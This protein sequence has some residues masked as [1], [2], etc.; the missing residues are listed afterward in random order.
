MMKSNKH[1]V[2]FLY[3]ELAGYITA[4][5]ERLAASGIEV[6]VFAYPVNAEAP[7]EFSENRLAHYYNRKGFNTKTLDDKLN[8]ISPNVVVCSGWIDELYIKVCRRLPENVIRV[9]AFDN[10][11][12][13][14]LKSWVS[15]LRARF[16]FKSVFEIAWVPGK[17]QWKYAEKMGFDGKDIYIGF[18]TADAE[19]LN[20]LKWKGASEF[21]KKFFFVGRYLA[22]KGVREMWNAYLNLPSNDWELICAGQGALYEKRTQAAGIKHLGFVQPEE[23]EKLMSEGGVFILPSHK[24]P[25]GVVVHEFASAG[26][27]LICTKEVGAASAFLENEKNGF[28]I[29]AK[30]QQALE[31]AM[32]EIMAMSNEQL[33]AFGKRSS[34]LAQKITIGKWIKTLNEIIARNE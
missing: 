13:G 11:F 25:W 32:K 18:Y 6:H 15:V 24:E 21:P 19:K 26:F 7:F 3:T 16:K 33:F 10:G 34:E 28:L 5:M 12:S 22:F 23:M 8:E 29:H 30:S 2:V 4:C 9:L 31:K 27:P 14:S 20:A 1:K 17:P